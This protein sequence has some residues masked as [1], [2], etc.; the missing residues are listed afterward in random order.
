[1]HDVAKQALSK[2]FMV[3]IFILLWDVVCSGESQQNVKKKIS[4]DKK[5]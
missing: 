2:L 4:N 1:M 3:L 5:E